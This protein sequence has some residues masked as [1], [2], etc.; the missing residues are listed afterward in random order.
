M[1][2]AT[3]NE[4]IKYKSEKDIDIFNPK[5]EFFNDICYSFSQ[6]GN[7]ITI[8][9]RRDLIYKNVTL[10]EDKCIYIAINYTSNKVICNCSSSYISNSNSFTQEKTSIH[11]VNTLNCISS[12]FTWKN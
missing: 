6:D 5:D 2:K 11:N 4:G 8:K 9:D 1:D 7:D 10:C 3:L 12:T